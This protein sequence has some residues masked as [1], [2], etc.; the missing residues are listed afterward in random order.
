[1]RE[2]WFFTIKNIRGV[3]FFYAKEFA[4]FNDQI[5]CEYAY[6]FKIEQ[7]RAFFHFFF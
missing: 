2:S 5:P 6:C 1:M 3:V 7:A 4:S